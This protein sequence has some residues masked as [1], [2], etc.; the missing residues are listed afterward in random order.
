MG[1]TPFVGVGPLGAIAISPDGITWAEISSITDRS[2]HGIGYGDGLF[3]AVGEGSMILTSTDGVNW[4]Y[5]TSGTPGTYRAV[6]YGNG[7]FVIVGYGIVLT[8]PDGVTWT[9]QSPGVAGDFSAIAY[10]NGTFVAVAGDA[11]TIRS[12][13][14]ISWTK[15]SGPVDSYDFLTGV[16]FG[17]EMFVAVGYECMDSEHIHCRYM[18]PVIFTSSSGTTWDRRA[19]GIGHGDKLLGIAFGNGAFVAVGTLG[20]ILTSFHPMFSVNGITWAVRESNS[21]A[22]LSGVT[23]GDRS[24]VVLGDYGTI[25]QSDQFIFGDIPSGH[26]A[27]EPI[28][29]LQ[30]SGVTAGCGN[31]DYCPMIR[32][33]GGRWLF[34]S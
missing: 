34:S 1:R 7:L 24:F 20:T 32:S 31:G 16:A 5:R 8:S 22:T 6:A 27:E 23:Y 11:T 13:D 21:S 12:T 9:S 15:G 25:L 28:I 3:V 30:D 14:G 29:L 19:L 33:P 2:L 4:T 26:W 10:G 17:K 18:T